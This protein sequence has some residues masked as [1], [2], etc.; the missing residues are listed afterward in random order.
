MNNVHGGF[1][2]M[3]AARTS[4]AGPEAHSFH[5]LACSELIDGHLAHKA[6]DASSCF[7]P[8]SLC[9]VDVHGLY[10]LAR[11]LRWMLDMVLFGRVDP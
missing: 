8:Y 2:C 1:V 7:T 6:F 10:L 11:E 5:V 9:I 4:V 3:E